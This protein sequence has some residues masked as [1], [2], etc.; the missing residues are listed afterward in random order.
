MS[1]CVAESITPAILVLPGRPL[2]IRTRFQFAKII[3]WSDLGQALIMQLC[4]QVELSMVILDRK[5]GRNLALKRSTGPLG[6]KSHALARF[7][8]IKKKNEGGLGKRGL[9][10]NRSL[11]HLTSNCLIG[12]SAFPLESTA[13]EQQWQQLEELKELEEMSIVRTRSSHTKI[14]N[15]IQNHVMRMCNHRIMIIPTSSTGKRGKG[16]RRAGSLKKSSVLVTSM[17]ESEERMRQLYRQQ[18]RILI[19]SMIHFPSHQ[20]RVL[21]KLSLEQQRRISTVEVAKVSRRKENWEHEERGQMNM[22]S[23]VPLTGS[24]G[25]ESA[26]GH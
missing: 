6:G 7:H 5:L 14:K 18:S 3:P 23:V 2:G 8:S 16:K 24:A 19:E 11:D 25:T 17:E 20:Q 26:L 4:L 9:S 1:Q 12:H 13:K 15:H 22:V 10:R 21:Q